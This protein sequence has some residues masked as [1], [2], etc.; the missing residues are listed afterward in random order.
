MV[1]VNFVVD[2]E[3]KS[4][5]AK[6]GQ[7]LLEI[8]ENNDI[9]VSAPCGG[10]LACGQCHVVIDEAFFSKTGEVSEREQDV[11]D[12]VPDVTSTSRLACQVKVTEELDGIIVNVVSL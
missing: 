11:L 4:V 12:F 8:A 9:P 2:G 1:K 6:V 10:N 3:T 5:D 7:T